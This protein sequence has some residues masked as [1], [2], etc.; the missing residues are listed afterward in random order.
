MLRL[1]DFNVQWGSR[2]ILGSVSESELSLQMRLSEQSVYLSLQ[3]LTG[4]FFF[5]LTAAVLH[6][7]AEVARYR[8]HVWS[9]E[10][11]GG[12]GHLVNIR[13]A[14][15]LYPAL[16]YAVLLSF[17][18]TFPG[19]GISG[20]LTLRSRHS[21]GRKALLITASWKSQVWTVKLGEWVMYTLVDSRDLKYVLVFPVTSVNNLE[22]KIRMGNRLRY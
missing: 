12:T 14:W 21:W 6:C 19:E 9:T 5:F 18:K 13:K 11:E 1:V 4:L 16:W 15:G 2:I 17:D 10:L 22:K 8:L 20:L 3:S 7:A